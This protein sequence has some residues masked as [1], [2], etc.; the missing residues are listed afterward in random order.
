MLVGIDLG[1]HKVCTIIGQA[2]PGGGLRLLGIG[3]APAGDGI[4][5]GEV[6]HVEEAA[7]A[8]ASSLERAERIAGDTIHGVHVGVTGLHVRSQNNQAAVPCGRRPRPIDQADVVRVLEAAGTIPLP[9]GREVLHVL[10]RAFRL[11]DGGPILSPVGMEGCQLSTEVHIVTAGTA[12]L[13]AV[14]RCLAMAETGPAR[15]VMSTLAAAEA[16]LTADERRLGVFVVDLGHACTGL[17]CFHDGTALHT[18]VL[19]V[20]GRHMT[21]DLAVVLQTPV[22]HAEEIKET[23]GHV[24]PDLDDGTTQI[25]VIPFGDGERSTTTRR[26]V[27]EILAARADEIAGLVNAELERAGMAGRLA[28]GAVLVG[29]G[30]EL[31]GLAR[32]LCEQWGAPVRI[33]RP[34]GC[35]APRAFPC[36][37]PLTAHLTRMAA[38]MPRDR[39]PEVTRRH[40]CQ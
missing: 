29:G 19:Q 20:G 37:A 28:A 21:N 27:S 10:P 14:R 9:D 6:V 24:L 39:H 5:N 26:H 32:R 40:S 13:A 17:A 3:H 33:G 36:L 12:P 4:R 25:P 8:I 2:L 30:S 34:H 38:L 18:A 11:D 7:G 22:R 23:Y 15:L 31:G 16:T 1:S 35:S